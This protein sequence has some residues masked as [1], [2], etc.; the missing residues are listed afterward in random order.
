MFDCPER[1]GLLTRVSVLH[2]HDIVLVREMVEIGVD[3]EFRYNTHRVFA[4]ETMAFAALEGNEVPWMI[5]FGGQFL[6]RG[7][8]GHGY[9][10]LEDSPH[11]TATV[12]VLPAE[13]LPRINHEDFGAES[14]PLVDGDAFNAREEMVCKGLGILFRDDQEASPRAAKVLIDNS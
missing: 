6:V 7:A 13:A 14:N 3:P 9:R 8:G 12:V 5:V 1:E 11:L 2:P 4:D 10:A